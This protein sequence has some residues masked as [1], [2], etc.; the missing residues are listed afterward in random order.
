MRI[1]HMAISQIKLNPRNARTHSAKQIRQ[2]AKSIVEFGFTNP[3]LVDEDGEL[4]AGHGRYRAA[5][6]LGIE[7]VPVIIVAG[8]SPA[9]R[10]ALA[11]AD[12]RIAENARWD[13]ARLAIEIPEL[14]DLLSAEGLDVSI[15]GFEPVEIGHLQTEFE[16][17][18]PPLNNDAIDPAWG[19]A[20]AVSRPGDLWVLGSHK[21]LCGDV[22][23]ADLGC[24]MADCRADMAFLDP[25]RGKPAG[26]SAFAAADGDMSSRDSVRFLSRT[27]D[28][29]A[30]VSREG[31]V[32]L[33]CTDR[34]CIAELMAAAEPIYG[35]AVDVAVWEKSEADPGFLYRSEL[36][37]IFVFGIRPLN[38][39]TGGPMRS[40]S[41]IWHYRDVKA[42]GGGNGVRLPPAGKPV[43][44]IAD[45]L[46]DCTRKGDIVLDPFAGAGTTVMAAE[47]VG[48]H[49]RALEVDPRL[50]DVAIRRWQAVARGDAVRA[51]SGLSFD[52]IAAG[53]RL[54]A[55]A[56]PHQSEI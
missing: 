47:R 29:A 53:R 7:M 48:R 36:E 13:R 14:S 35:E 51:D 52:D 11:I 25:P 50:V 4:I 39:A 56:S 12:N 18:A 32:H 16:R 44:F 2:I 55:G 38:I 20:P 6:L 8:L 15:L 42:S 40:R 45:V 24:L 19:E 54:S 46:K 31:A 41:N 22:G 1:Q 30:S 3:L 17:P 34:R 37:F 9:K 5:V 10:R 26:P 28:A 49:A 27:F 43:G 21:L 23:G 33:V